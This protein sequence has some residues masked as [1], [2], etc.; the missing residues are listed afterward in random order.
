MIDGTVT[1]GNAA[2]PP[3][4]ISNATV[5]GIGS[6]TVMTTTAAPGATAGQY[7][8][9]G[10]GAGSYTVSLSKTTGQNGIT[11]NDAARIAQH[12]AGTNLLNT[13]QKVVADVSDNNAVSSFDAGLIATYVVSGPPSGIAGTWKFFVPPGPTFP[14]GS[15]PTSRIYESVTGSISGEDY[16]GL[17]IGDVSGNWTNT[18]ARP[19]G[20][21]Q[22]QLAE[23]EGSDTLVR[24]KIPS[25]VTP[26]DKEVIVPIGVERAANQGIISYEFDLR[27]DP[28]IMQP[29]AEPVDV[30][31]TASRGFA[32]VT[33]ATEPGL[34][35]VVVYGAMPIDH[36]GVLL[37]L[38]FNAVGASG[39][40]SPL[41]W[42]RIL[43]NEGDPQVTVTNGQV[44]L[45]AAE[46]K[47]LF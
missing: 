38:R 12:V 20:S 8:L 30:A 9:S 11:S 45:S 28:S 27:Y 10:F 46:P 33:N 17:L 32:V 13:T 25:L 26:L 5:T 47:P 42:E 7:S 34:L 29:Q 4:F 41:I 37:N 23:Q 36:D 2:A 14:V 39:S 15:S 21:W 24:V 31:G 40:I 43:F 19:V 1:Y 16:I 18:G 44:E 35:R 3:K 22:R 6:P